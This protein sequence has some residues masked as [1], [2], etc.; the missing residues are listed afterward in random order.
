[1]VSYLYCTVKCIVRSPFYRTSHVQVLITGVLVLARV[2]SSTISHM[3]I[4]CEHEVQC[5][6]VPCTVQFDLVSGRG[7]VQYSTW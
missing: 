2:C 6:I 5:T 1:M 7:T 4:C 3:Y